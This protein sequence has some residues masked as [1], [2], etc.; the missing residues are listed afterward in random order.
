MSRSAAAATALA[1]ALVLSL[2]L[3][4][5]IAFFR[6]VATETGVEVREAAHAWQVWVWAP[7]AWIEVHV[8]QPWARYPH[9]VSLQ[10]RAG[11]ACVFF[12]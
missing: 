12:F 2:Y 9:G 1:S 8:W 10:S 6:P 3:I 7:A 4:G 11:D 5:Y